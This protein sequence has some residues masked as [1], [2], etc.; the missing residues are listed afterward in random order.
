MARRMCQ[1]GKPKKRT[2]RYN[3]NRPV[4]ADVHVLPSFRGLHPLSLLL[5]GLAR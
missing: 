2:N 1:R 3:P 4:W 5:A